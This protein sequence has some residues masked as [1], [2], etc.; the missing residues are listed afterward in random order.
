MEQAQQAID[1]FRRAFDAFVE[2]G[3]TVNVVAV[4]IFPHQ[5]LAFTS[6]TADMPA[7]ALDMVTPDSIEAAYLLCQHGIARFYQN[8]DHE[9]A[10]ENLGGAIEIAQREGDSVLAVHAL[11]YAATVELFQGHYKETIEKGLRAIELAQPIGELRSL[12]RARRICSIALADMGECAEAQR[13]ATACLEAAERLHDNLVLGEVLYQNT[14]L[15]ILKGEWTAAQEFNTRALAELPRDAYPRGASA[16]LHFHVG[17]PEE[18]RWYI[19]QVLEV[20][21]DVPVAF[22]YQHASAAAM[23]PLFARVTGTTDL[24]EVAESYAREV[25]SSPSTPWYN[26]GLVRMGLAL[27]A[28]LQSDVESAVEQYSFLEP[29]RGALSP[30]SVLSA[31]RVLGLLAQTMGKHDDA[32]DHFEDALAF[33]RRAGYRPELAWSCCDYAD[34]LTE[35]DGPGD[36]EKAMK[37]LDESLEISAELGMRPL[38]ERVQSRQETLR[39]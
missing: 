38:M 23:I 8:N 28:V 3:D 13:H 35:R 4:A 15:A 39:S 34:M 29:H 37:L 14:R 21:P 16:L 27:I 12:V 9:G 2:L 7:R 19:E 20:V 24:L 32:K 25:L 26:I 31:D 18:S 22:G 1:T 36:H 11:A 30:W 5:G 6:G 10:K 17:D 33:C